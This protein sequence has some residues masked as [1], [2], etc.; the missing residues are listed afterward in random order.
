MSIAKDEQLN[1]VSGGYVLDYTIKT[2]LRWIYRALFSFCRSGVEQSRVGRIGP[3]PALLTAATDTELVEL[4]II[5]NRSCYIT[6]SLFT[7]LCFSINLN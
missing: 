2:R 5:E 3:V 1:F 7:K 4:R 6:S